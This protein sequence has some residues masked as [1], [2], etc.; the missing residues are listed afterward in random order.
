LGIADIGAAFPALLG[1][2]DI[3]AAFPASC[4]AFAGATNRRGALVIFSIGAAPT[5]S[6][7]S[8]ANEFGR[9][10]HPPMRRVALRLPLS[11]AGTV[12]VIFCRGLI[13]LGKENA[14]SA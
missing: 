10:A 1:I 8:G 7:H 4:A 2:A 12:G 6:G 11:L 13:P 14:P 3:G 5:V 9:H